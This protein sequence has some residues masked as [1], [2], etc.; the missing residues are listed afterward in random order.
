MTQMIWVFQGTFSIELVPEVNLRSAPEGTIIFERSVRSPLAT[1]V[2]E[3][4]VFLRNGKVRISSPG[5]EFR[6]EAGVPFFWHRRFVRRVIARDRQLLWHARISANMRVCKRCC[7]SGSLFCP[8]KGKFLTFKICSTCGGKGL[9]GRV[10]S[11][12]V[13]LKIDR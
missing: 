10:K 1:S 12:G 11:A 8:R 5:P 2:L 13:S 3:R 6:T 9:K 7:G 4:T